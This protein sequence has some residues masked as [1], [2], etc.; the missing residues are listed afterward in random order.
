[1][2]D[3][4][5]PERRSWLMSRVRSQDTIP[6]LV[7]RRMLHANGYRYRLHRKDL[8]GNPDI[9]FVRQR[10]VIFI[11]GCFWHR[12]RGC[13]KAS[14]PSTRVDYWQNKFERNVRRDRAVCRALR[15]D[16]WRVLTIW[17]CQTKH[18]EKLFRRVRKF[19]GPA[20]QQTLSA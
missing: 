6:E 14:T 19:L 12:H 9:V 3:R 7:V 5:S 11:H 4:L 10:A 1:M 16:N 17:E 8:P 18:P 2:T 13:K 20:R 15:K